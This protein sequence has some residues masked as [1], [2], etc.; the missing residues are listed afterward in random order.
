VTTPNSPSTDFGYTGQRQLDAG[1]GGLM[2]YKA[3]FYSPILGRFVQPDSLIPDPSNSQAWN[4]YSYVG[5][6]PIGYNDPS[7]HTRVADLDFSQDK[8]RMNCSKY[9]QYCNNGKPIFAGELAKMR[10]KNDGKEQSISDQI[11]ANKYT[12][13]AAAAVQV[14][15]GTVMSIATPFVETPIGLGIWIGAFAV[16]RA[17]SLLG[18]ASTFYQYD[19]KLY[20]TN[21]T[22]VVVN[23][24]AFTFGWIPSLTEGLSIGILVY[25]SIR[26]DH[27]APVDIPHPDF[28]K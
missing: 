5:N 27:E 16:N 4:R 22:D 10:H 9:P 1:M 21:F 13:I 14:L 12:P 17:S 25:S 6:N 7:G 8:S 26:L 18:L 11:L 15:S 19:K 20:G 28:L 23:G 24:A 2:D 3:R